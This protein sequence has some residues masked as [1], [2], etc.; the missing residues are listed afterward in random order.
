LIKCSFRLNDLL[1]LSRLYLSN[2]KSLRYFYIISRRSYLVWKLKSWVNLL[3]LSIV[4]IQ[5]FWAWNRAQTNNL[6]ESSDVLLWNA[7]IWY[8]NFD[9]YSFMVS[10]S[11]RLRTNTQNILVNVNCIIL[12]LCIYFVSLVCLWLTNTVKGSYD[13][14]TGNMIFYVTN[15]KASP[16][17]KTTLFD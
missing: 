3:F 15:F 8:F 5:P 12:L 7:R 10:L 17:V 16:A 9:I 11:E 1:N 6:F 2:S 4:W 13:A 14:E